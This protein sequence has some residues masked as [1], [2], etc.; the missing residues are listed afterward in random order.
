M[1]TE[2]TRDAL[3]AMQCVL[4]TLAGSNDE[5]LLVGQVDARFALAAKLTRT[6]ARQVA[7][8]EVFDA[9]GAHTRA[10]VLADP[11]EDALELS[12]FELPL[13][14]LLSHEENQVSLAGKNADARGVRVEIRLSETG[15][16]VH[17][18]GLSTTMSAEL[19]RWMDAAPKGP[20]R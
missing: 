2:T 17:H 15:A 1:S 9:I 8:D 7:T 11:D 20:L 14:I 10:L 5:V 18:E 13:I 19:G 6:R 3:Y 4:L 12:A 16:D